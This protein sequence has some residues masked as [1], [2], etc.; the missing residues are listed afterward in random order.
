MTTDLRIDLPMS[1]I[2]DFCRRWKI[3]E[4]AILGSILRDD[5]RP[6][7]DVDVLATFDDA[8]TWTLL[9]HVGMQDELREMLG[10]HVDLLTRAGVEHSANPER[11]REIL[12]SARVVH[13]A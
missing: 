12:E 1:A 8:A 6:D 13:A 7:S 3:R 4:F 11:R 9:D 5:F 10:R 2:A